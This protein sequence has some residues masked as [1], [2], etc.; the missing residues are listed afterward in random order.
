LATSNI[1]KEVTTDDA[2]EKVKSYPGLM[3]K[4]PAYNNRFY[5]AYDEKI[6]EHKEQE[7][8]PEP[9][10]ED[11][12]SLRFIYKARY[13]ESLLPYSLYEANGLLNEDMKS[14]VLKSTNFEILI[15]KAKAHSIS[16]KTSRTW[17]LEPKVPK[18]EKRWIFQANYWQYYIPWRLY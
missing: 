13:P 11:D 18:T 12:V 6:Y 3:Y 15:A 7:V 10:D 8:I 1:A 16:H 14:N 17:G 2:L 9:K 4:T 5:D